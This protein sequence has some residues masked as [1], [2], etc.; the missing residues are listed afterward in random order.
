MQLWPDENWI[1]RSTG[2][3]GMAVVAAGAS[4]VRS[5]TACTKINQKKPWC[6][7]LHRISYR[8]ISH[9]FISWN[10]VLYIDFYSVS[11]LIMF[12]K[13]EH[14]HHKH[15]KK[16]MICGCF[17]KCARCCSMCRNSPKLPW[18]MGGNRTQPELIILLKMEWTW[19]ELWNMCLLQG[20]VIDGFECFWTSTGCKDHRNQ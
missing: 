3:T 11:C 20:M 8:V 13:Y 14:K 5:R 4:S 18:Q 10:H 17:G 2:P 16:H 9:H 1:G 12:I 19:N 6:I 15:N 7:S